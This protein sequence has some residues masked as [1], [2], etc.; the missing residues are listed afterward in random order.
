MDEYEYMWIPVKYI[1]EYIMEEYNLKELIHN[2]QVM[3]EIMKGMYGLP[4]AGIL[5]NDCL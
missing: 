4:Q 2:G 1:P 3:V 5:A